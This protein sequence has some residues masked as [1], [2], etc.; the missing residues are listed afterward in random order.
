MNSNV[1]LSTP[2]LLSSAFHR[3]PHLLTNPS[4]ILCQTT[5]PYTTSR[6]FYQSP[7]LILLDHPCHIPS[8]L[9][10]F[11]AE[12][13][14]LPLLT[15][16]PYHSPLTITITI[17]DIPDTGLLCDLLWADPDKDIVGWGENDRGVS[18]TFGE[19][20]V[21]QFLRRYVCSPEYTSCTYMVACTYCMYRGFE[22]ISIHRNITFPSAC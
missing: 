18:F 22:L 11:V 5:L 17:S 2:S 7:Y 12:H 3:I 14:R 15:S 4:S 20:V 16:S 10:S 9:L 1:L 8:S 6:D 13:Q 21:A 19:D